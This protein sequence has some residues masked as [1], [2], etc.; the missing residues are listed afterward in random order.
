MLIR[1]SIVR[2]FIPVLFLTISTKLVSQTEDGEIHFPEDF[3]NSYIKVVS[4]EITGNE[5]TKEQIVIREMD[6]S[7][8]DSLATFEV[9]TPG[10]AQ[11]GQKRFSMADSS[12]VVRRMRYSRENIINTK[13]FLTVDMYLEEVEGKSYKIRI[14]VK[15][16]WYF[17]VFPVIQLDHPN[18]NDWLK[19][20]DFSLL[21]QG[22]FVSHN[23]MW[24]L[25]HQASFI[26]YFGSSNG[27]GLGYY[28]PW[29]GKGQ[30]IGLRIGGIYRN[31]SV[32]EYGSL[33]NERQL[34]FEPGSMKEF[35]LVNTLTLRPGLYNYGKVKVAFDNVQ[36]S[37]ELYNRTLDESLAS[38]LPLGM[39]DIY[40]LSLYAE[41]AYDSRNNKA[42]PL[43]GT[44][45]KGFVDKY[46]LGIISHDVDYF[47]YGVDMHFYQRISDR[48]Y[49]SEMFKLVESSG[50]N[51][52]YK[53]K[54]NLTSGDD[55]I[56]GYDLYALRG[57]DMYYFRSNLKYNVIKP[58]ILPPRKEKHKDSK[59][60]NVPYAFYI[61]LI[62]D[63]GFMRD[64]FYGDY[65]PYNNKGLFSWGLGMDFI[66]YYDLVLRFEYM[67]TSIGTH[68][69][70]FGFG[71]PI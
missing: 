25:S 16:R 43:K 6:F 55:F 41:Y 26:G 7:M 63:V 30:K 27:L 4:Y 46:G 51:I 15:E 9:K 64:E 32:V 31:S 65:N 33:Q 18:F 42:Y 68:G 53:F 48:W 21:T 50:E 38:F 24:G 58:G 59:F 70:F 61:N 14:D 13:L 49:T 23:N 3:S 35:T 69:F 56:R 29:I 52:S 2:L 67:Y 8:D 45:M 22:I 37:D 60:R 71:M 47:Y 17:W 57:D 44:Y 19:S 20:P 28:I 34:I 39:Q 11:N 66:S 54:Q 12:E 5:R 36:I 1:H 10:F 40:Y 62:A